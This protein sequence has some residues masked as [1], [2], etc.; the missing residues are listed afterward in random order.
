VANIA[1]A[2][3]SE[4]YKGC[5]AVAHTQ[6]DDDSVKLCKGCALKVGR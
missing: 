3:T 1:G 6:T 5:G 4:V 2:L